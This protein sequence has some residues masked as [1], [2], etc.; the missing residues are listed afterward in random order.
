MRLSQQIAEKSGKK[1]K[2]G[3]KGVNG[4]A[5]EAEKPKSAKDL[6]GKEELTVHEF[7]ALLHGDELQTWVRESKARWSK[8]RTIRGLLAYFGSEHVNTKINMNTH[9]FCG[10]VTVHMMLSN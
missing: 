8:L 3:K 4:D 9:V 6:T 1:G 5:K 2:K 7:M 10:G